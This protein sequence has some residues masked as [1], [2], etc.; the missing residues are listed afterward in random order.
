MSPDGSKAFPDALLHLRAH[1]RATDIEE[2]QE[3]EHV[4]ETGI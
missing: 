1:P 2:R 3:A 4:D